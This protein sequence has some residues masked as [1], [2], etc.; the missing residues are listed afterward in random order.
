MSTHQF[1]T[2]D[3][4]IKINDHSVKVRRNR[5][6]IEE[7]I[8]KLP[9]LRYPIIL[10]MPHNDVEIRTQI[11]LTDGKTFEEYVFLDMSFEEY[12]S[13]P[14]LEIDPEKEVTNAS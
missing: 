11:L 12:G 9:D 6:L 2:K 14:S 8:A 1:I 10:A 4:L 13:L 7:S 3:L 5:T